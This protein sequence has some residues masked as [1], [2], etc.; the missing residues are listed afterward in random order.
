MSILSNH[1]HPHPVLRRMVGWLAL[2]GMIGILFGAVGLLIAGLTYGLSL[3]ILMIPFLLGMIFPLIILTALHP[4]ITLQ[5][6]GV[7]IK[8]LVW[9]TRLVSWEQLTGL[10]DH[11]LMKPP[12][13][14]RQQNLT[15]R[16]VTKGQM[17]LVEKG[18]LG[19]PFRIV[20]FAAGH[21]TTPVFAISSKTHRDYDQLLQ[22]LK[23]RIPQKKEQA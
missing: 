14:A 16:P 12:P 17:I 22:T 23:R 20:G 4:Q 3:M 19:W 1:P 2:A 11:S 18:A 15:K 8:P 10:T 21:G 13:P 9:K 5:E 6:E 7:Q